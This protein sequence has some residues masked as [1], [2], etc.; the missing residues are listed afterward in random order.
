MPG[1]R[2]KVV[3]VSL[4]SSKRDSKVEI[5]MMGIPFILQRVGTDGDF[6][7]AKNLIRDLD[8]EVDAIGLGGIDLYLVTGIKRYVV[9]DAK[10]LADVAKVTP[11]V[12]GAFLK[13]ALEREAILQ[14]QREGLVDFKGMKVLQVSAVD[15]IGMASALGSLA[16]EIVY[17]DLMFAF[18]FPIP[19]RSMR[20]VNFLGFLFL[21][22]ICRLPFK[23]LYPTGAEQEKPGKPRFPQYFQW[24]DLIAGDFHYIRRYA[25]PELPGKIVLTNTTTPADVEWLR[26]KGVKMLITTT[27]AIQG[28]SLGV[29]VWEGVVV[30]LL[31]KRAEEISEEEY[32]ETMRKI[33]WAPRVEML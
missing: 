22:L 20:A 21:P 7:R 9:K 15:R 16:K 33:G 17:G 4:G 18:G 27:P 14:L 6:E 2:K 26:Q 10:K 5:E 28:R 24:A 8:G 1:E 13:H 32:I 23:M 25:P 3:S 29:N 19:M 31:G 11:V 12:D 30:S